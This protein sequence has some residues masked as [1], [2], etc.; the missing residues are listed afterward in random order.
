M[1]PHYVYYIHHRKGTQREDVIFECDAK[2]R[3]EADGKCLAAG[4]DPK[5]LLCQAVKRN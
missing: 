4:H 3:V 2:D 1:S 5:K